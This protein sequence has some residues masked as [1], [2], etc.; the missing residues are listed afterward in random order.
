[1]VSSNDPSGPSAGQAEP[2][3][4]ALETLRRIIV[5][6]ETDRLGELEQRLDDPASRIEETSRILPDAISL[7]LARDQRL[8]G[9][10][11]A[12]IEEAILDSVRKDPKVLA[13]AIFPLMGPGIRRAIS[14][15]IM[16]MIQNVNQL[17]N[18][19]FSIQGLKWRIEAFRT[20]RPYAEIVLLHTLVYQVEQIF[21]VHRASGLVLQHVS[22]GGSHED[23]DMVSGMLTAIEDFVTDS[24]GGTSEQGLDTLRIGNQRSIWIE[25]GSKAYMAA[26]IRGTPPLALRQRMSETLASIHI[27]F[28]KALDEYEGDTLAF[29]SAEEELDTLLDT[30][31]KRSRQKVS[32][33]LWIATAVLVGLLLAWGI[34]GLIFDQ[35]CERL[36]A[37]LRQEP[38]VIVIDAEKDGRHL[39][40]RGLK[41][42]LAEDPSAFPVDAGLRGRQVSFNFRPFSSLDPAFVLERAKQ[43][44]ETPSTVSLQLAGDR[45]VATGSAEHRWIKRLKTTWPALPGIGGI[46][47]DGLVDVDMEA[48]APLR[49][50]IEQI[51]ILFPFRLSTMAEGQERELAELT[52]TL[53]ELARLSKK[54]EAVLTVR[55]QGYADELGTEEANLWISQQRAQTV[56]RYIAQETDVA[57]ATDW[58]GMGIYPPIDM[59]LPTERKQ[60]LRRCV[61]FRLVTDFRL[62]DGDS[63]R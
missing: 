5:G 14:A 36:L 53:G 9:S 19:S 37:M 50:K 23:P 10:L 51:R 25:Q 58:V 62:F 30:E 35:R 18:H 8:A 21:L 34:T 54:L 26:V 44:L 59:D 4:E 63:T 6:P 24:F 3:T 45:L 7:S 32:P 2:Q 27:L 39:A 41:D 57:L 49:R 48:I 1:M 61:V 15:A 42:P 28:Q 17:L 31:F 11:R 20:N 13:N 29:E 22:S 60:A 46:I 47:A 33:L 38:G 16:G 40:V 56:L 52:K 43:T 55:I 12:T